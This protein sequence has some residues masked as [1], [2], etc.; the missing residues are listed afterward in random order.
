MKKT[1]LFLMGIGAA[2]ILFGCEKQLIVGSAEAESLLLEKLY[3]ELDSLATLTP[4]E[5]N[6]KWRFTAVGEKACGGPAGYLAYS[7]DSDTTTFLAKVATYTN[8]QSA[9]NQKWN[10]VSDCMFV[11]APSRVACENGKPKLV[12]DEEQR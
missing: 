1:R 6:E 5:H 11:V 7:T 8:F 2:L 3:H 4:C 9:Y 10:V 12:W